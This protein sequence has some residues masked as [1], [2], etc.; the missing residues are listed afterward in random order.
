MFQVTANVRSCPGLEPSPDLWCAAS[1][2]RH[3]DWDR[4]L[5]SLANFGLAVFGQAFGSLATL[6]S[7]GMAQTYVS[8][9]SAHPVPMSVAKDVCILKW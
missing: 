3:P 7:L 6:E 4:S 2:L 8:L 1:L 5:A 9:G